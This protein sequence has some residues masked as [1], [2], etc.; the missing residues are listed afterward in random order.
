MVG[1]D[2]AVLIAVV[3]SLVSL[4]KRVGFPAKFAP[5]LALVLGVAAGVIYAVP[6]DLYAGILVGIVMGL[7]SVGLYSGPKN[8][9]QG[10]KSL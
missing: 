9:K 8:V 2:D 10:V 1:M 3:T 5:L 4:A 7:A 6:D